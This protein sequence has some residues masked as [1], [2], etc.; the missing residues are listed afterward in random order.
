MEGHRIARLSL[1]LALM[2]PGAGEIRAQDRQ[3]DLTQTELRREAQRRLNISGRQRMLSQRIAKA[4]CLTMRLPS[5][6]E[7][8][9][10]MQEARALFMSSMKALRGGSAEIGLTAENDAAAA[11]VERSRRACRPV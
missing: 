3:T 5:N 8:A 9:K 2:L 7:L 10:E 11:M 6:G 1:V 4:A